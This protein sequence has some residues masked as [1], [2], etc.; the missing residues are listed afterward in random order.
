MVSCTESD[1]DKEQ[2]TM[3][4]LLLYHRMDVAITGVR[5]YDYN[6]S[7]QAL[8]IH[9]NLFPFLSHIGLQHWFAYTCEL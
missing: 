7:N 3:F 4:E 6:N 2:V 1:K 5:F 8:S 9:N